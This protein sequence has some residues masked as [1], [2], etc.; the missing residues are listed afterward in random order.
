[1][2]NNKLEEP[3]GQAVVIFENGVLFVGDQRYKASAN[4][5]NECGVSVF[6]R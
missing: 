5:V 2:G 6:L 3:E 1:M 4:W